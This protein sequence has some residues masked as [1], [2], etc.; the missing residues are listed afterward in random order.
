MLRPA[1]FIARFHH[2]LRFRR[3]AVL[4]KKARIGCYQSSG[5]VETPTTLASCPARSSA[6]APHCSKGGTSKTKIQIKTS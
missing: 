3:T 2:N 1:I 5:V 6:Q 4:H